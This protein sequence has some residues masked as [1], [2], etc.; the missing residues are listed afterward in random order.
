MAFDGR[1][2][3]Y[4]AAADADGNL[5]CNEHARMTNAQIT[6][7]KARGVRYTR[8]EITASLRKDPIEAIPHCDEPA[9][10][11]SLNLG[12]LQFMR[13]NYP[14]TPFADWPER[15]AI[16]G[17]LVFCDPYALVLDTPRG[18]LL[19]E[20]DED[21]SRDYHGSTVDGSNPEDPWGRLKLRD[22]VGKYVGIYVMSFGPNEEECDVHM[23]IYS[24]PHAKSASEA[25]L[26]TEAAH[27]RIE[28]A[29]TFV[30]IPEPVTPETVRVTVLGT[31]ELAV[32]T[33]TG[34]YFA[35]SYENLAT[36]HGQQ[37]AV[38]DVISFVP[39]I[40]L[41]GNLNFSPDWLPRPEQTMLRSRSR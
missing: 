8:D 36:R 10:P 17:K 41:D 32:R 38:G 11:G 13:N 34:E 3:N 28:P 26:L 15:G 40:G 14:P 33:L 21:V 20:F 35:T 4:I 31:E 39:T 2:N 24:L 18:P 25:R 7:E 5:Q 1:A 16:A 22:S 23:E 27:H 19:E 37:F 9:E 12:A 30:T 29:D 6:D